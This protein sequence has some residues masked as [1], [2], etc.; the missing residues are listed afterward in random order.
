MQEEE[1]ITSTDSL[2]QLIEPPSADLP[3]Y[4]SDH[5]STNQVEPSGPALDGSS[6]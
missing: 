6:Q 5:F 1:L 3:L 4:P 2:R